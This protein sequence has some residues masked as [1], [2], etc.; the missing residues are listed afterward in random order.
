LKHKYFTYIN[1]K[2]AA[3]NNNLTEAVFSIQNG[4]NVNISFDNNETPLII[5]L[6]Y[7][8]KN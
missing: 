3:K 5:G 4:A 2:K 8:K 6:F 7:N 1:I